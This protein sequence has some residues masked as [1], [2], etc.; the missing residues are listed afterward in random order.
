MCKTV[1][2]NL[3]SPCRCDKPPLSSGNFNAQHSVFHFVKLIK[4]ILSV[5]EMTLGN[6]A[7]S[8]LGKY[9][10]LRCSIEAVP[11]SSFEFQSVT[12]LLQHR[13]RTETFDV[14]LTCA[15][16]PS[17][18]ADY[19]IHHLLLRSVC[20]YSKDFYALF[21]FYFLIYCSEIYK[22]AKNAIFLWNNRELI[23]LD[24]GKSIQ[25][26]LI[27]LCNEVFELE[28]YISE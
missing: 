19:L 5:S 9:R 6:P 21:S 4:D 3:I 14:S 26:S 16:K 12:S 25:F 15:T 20:L 22:N 11:P 28:M 18:W 13:W 24:L 2:L 17:L 8:S 7:P 23:C 1:C 10:A 27:Q